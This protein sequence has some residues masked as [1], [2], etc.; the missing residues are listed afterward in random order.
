[1]DYMVIRC[2][3]ICSTLI[4]VCI[5]SND[6]RMDSFLLFW[7]ILCILTEI[8]RKRFLMDTIRGWPGAGASTTIIYGAWVA[9]GVLEYCKVAIKYLFV[10]SLSSIT[11]M[12]VLRTFRVFIACLNLFFQLPPSSSFLSYSL[13]LSYPF[14]LLFWVAF[15]ESVI[16]FLS[17]LLCTQ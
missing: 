10:L 12:I 16:T 15:P 11:N 3:Y 9:S 2:Q 5:R 8:A 4:K 13:P 7:R 14:F 6:H 1:M 17:S